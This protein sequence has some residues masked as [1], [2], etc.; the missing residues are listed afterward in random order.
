MTLTLVA[1]ALQNTT[2]ATRMAHG[3]LC[4]F[5]PKKESIEDLHEQFYRVANG[6]HGENEDKKKAI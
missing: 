1:N 4:E 5:H 3:M 6:I 2:L